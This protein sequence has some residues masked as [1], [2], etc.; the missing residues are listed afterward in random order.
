MARTRAVGIPVAVLLI[1]G[2]ALVIAIAAGWL[3]VHAGAELCVLLLPAPA[4]VVGVGVLFEH[5]HLGPRPKPGPNES[6][7][8]GVAAGVLAVQ[9]LLA[10]AVGAFYCLAA[11]TQAEVPAVDATP[12]MPA[13]LV[14][15]KTSESC[16]SSS[17]ALFVPVSSTD[18]AS[19]E[20]IVRRLG[21]P[22]ET[23]RPNGVLLDRRPRCIG[24][25][26]TGDTVQLYITI[27][28][29]VD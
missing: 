28:D 21:R 4:L 1:G 11:F 19:A 12:R 22:H 23:C 18:G 15:G 26:R 5:V 24:V 25:R 6:H 20:E 16:G 10:V 3:T 13:G 29:L 27:S 14:A 17:C 7:H 9:T 8:A 2:A